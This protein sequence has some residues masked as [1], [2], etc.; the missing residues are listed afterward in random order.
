[1]SGR[2]GSRGE[3]VTGAQLREAERGFIGI[4]RSKG[5]PGAWV[6]HNAL[7]LLAQASSE[8]AAWLKTHEPEENP[9]GWLITCAY[10]RALNLLE[11]QRR[12][13]PTSSVD[14]AL[15]IADERAPTPEQEVLD[16][17]RQ[18]RLR[19]A[20]DCLPAKDRRLISL[21]YF[22]GCTVREAGRRLGWRKSAAD[23]HHQAAL[24]RLRAIV[25]EDRS[26]LSPASL[27]LAAWIAA[28]R[29]HG[30]LRR[31]GES[32]RRLVPF[33]EPGS[34]IASGGGRLVAACG[35]GLAAAF[36]GLAATGVHPALP[37]ADKSSSPPPAHHRIAGPA[38]EA[39]PEAVVVAPPDPAGGEEA[40]GHRSSSVGAKAHRASGA[41]RPAA[42]Q[43][44]SRPEPPA[45]SEPVVEEFGIEGGS[46][47][48]PA[49]EEQVSTP[50]PAPTPQAPTRSAPPARPASGKQ[51]DEEFGL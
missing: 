43:P 37:G 31:L 35:A 18:G 1:M 25:G 17:E 8:Y 33:L 48:E 22:E 15:A 40:E 27:G 51:V 41:S 28:D 45:S 29:G 13:P 11:S 10:R 36:C 7:D 14:A 46:S 50:A 23:R 34:A 6:D 20:M 30:L 2:E 4:L 19:R 3:A 47:G 16:D 26:L 38:S 44:A 24:D 49:T 42:A 12:R 32:L 21:V 9:V 5:F 39:P